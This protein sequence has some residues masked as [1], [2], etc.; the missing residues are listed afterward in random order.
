MSGC[1][2]YDLPKTLTVCGTEY[3][4]CSDYREVLDVIEILND[5]EL[6]Q[7]E[8]AMG[9][10][11]FFYPQFED[12]PYAHFREALRKCFWFINGGKD[13]EQA[14][15]KPVRLVDWEQDFSC[16]VSPVNRVLGFEVRAQEYVHWW[17]FLGAYMEIG[18]CLFAQIVRI[19][20]AKARG[21][22]LEKHDRE[23]YER[24]RR[25]VDFRQNYT[26]Q[27]NELLKLWGGG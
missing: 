12:M 11:L 14:K 18:D 15:K 19:R 4:I 16:I 25:L 7:Q 2:F 1:G 3:E 20:D 27:E 13:E 17:T 8:K 6:D 24:N 26:Q 22:K 21:K 9:A 10:L 23:W 5:P